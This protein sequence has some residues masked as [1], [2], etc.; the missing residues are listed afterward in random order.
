MFHWRVRLAGG[1]VAQLRPWVGVRVKFVKLVI[2][3]GALGCPQHLNGTRPPGN[4]LVSSPSFGPALDLASQKVGFRATVRTISKKGENTNVFIFEAGTCS[5][6]VHRDENI[7]RRTQCHPAQ[8][9]KTWLSAVVWLYQLG[10]PPPRS[11]ECPCSKRK[12]SCTHSC[13]RW[14][15]GCLSSVD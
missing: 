1:E 14:C 13:V 12:H 4:T 3:F 9:G 10:P 7:S 2:H 11:S 15:S 5:S 6:V 8:R